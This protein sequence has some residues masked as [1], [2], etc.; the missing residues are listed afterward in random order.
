MIWIH[1]RRLRRWWVVVK[2]EI[3]DCVDLKNHLDSDPD[4]LAMILVRLSRR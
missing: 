2:E 3:K 1:W 4:V